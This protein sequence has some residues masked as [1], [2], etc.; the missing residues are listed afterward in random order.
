MIEFYHIGGGG[1]GG[2]SSPPAS[3]TLH[4][5]FFSRTLPFSLTLLI[6]EYLSVSALFPPIYPAYFRFIFNICKYGKWCS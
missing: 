1:E 3:H 2:W 5:P 6:E 4:Y